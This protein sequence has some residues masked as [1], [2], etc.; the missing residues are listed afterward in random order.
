MKQD[1]WVLLNQRPDGLLVPH[2]IYD[3][4]R[5]DKRGKMGRFQIRAQIAQVRSLPQLRL[6]WPWIRK[7]AE[8]SHHNISEK[9]L[10]NML[11]TACG[12]T[13]P[14][15]T[16]EGDMHLIPSSVAMDQ[17]GQEEF[18][19]YFESAQLI[20]SQKILPGVDLKTL[21][22]ATKDYAGWTDREAA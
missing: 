18:E 10:H 20:V 15:I 16:I 13:E 9:L 4:E 7:V 14:Y 21:M 1:N 22:K 8:N 3:R 5:V 2:G 19:Q 17:M 11:L 12:Y 6:Y